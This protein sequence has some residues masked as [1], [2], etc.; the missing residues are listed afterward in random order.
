M[1]YQNDDAPMT[2]EDSDEKPRGKPRKPRRKAQ[3]PD[4]ERDQL[5]YPWNEP[6]A[7][8]RSGDY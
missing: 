2:F 1:G 6:G 7:P 4:G 5:D 8:F 3:M